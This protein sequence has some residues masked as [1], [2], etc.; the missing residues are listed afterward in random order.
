MEGL[1]DLRGGV[2]GSPE[3]VIH[4]GVGDERATNS[5][6]RVGAGKKSAAPRLG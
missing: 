1:V 5:L 2:G 3:R 4:L 6:V